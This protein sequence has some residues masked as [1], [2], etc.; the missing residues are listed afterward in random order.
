LAIF[1]LARAAEAVELL[2]LGVLL[3]AGFVLLGLRRRLA[4][5]PGAR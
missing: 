1:A 3:L 5:T 4:A 2:T